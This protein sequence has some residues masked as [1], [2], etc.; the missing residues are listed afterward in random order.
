MNQF[1]GYSLKVW[2]VLISIV[3]KYVAVF[4]V[5]IAMLEYMLVDVYVALVFSV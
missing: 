1:L 5:F 4:M 2:K 3:V